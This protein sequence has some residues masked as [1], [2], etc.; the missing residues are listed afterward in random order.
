MQRTVGPIRNGDTEC[1]ED[2]EQACDTASDILWCALGYVCRGDCTDTADA[3]TRNN[4][5]CS[6]SPFVRYV[7][8]YECGRIART[9]VNLVQA[10]LAWPSDGGEDGADTEN[11]GVNHQR[12][13]TADRSFIRQKHRGS[14]LVSYLELHVTGI[15]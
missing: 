1:D 10:S 2:L 12:E 8:I 9:N 14:L 13:S 11:E 15:V 7:S 3:N 5:A 6:G 4:T